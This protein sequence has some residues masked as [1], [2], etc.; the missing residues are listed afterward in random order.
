ML[1]FNLYSNL[2]LIKLR[3]TSYATRC[4]WFSGPTLLAEGLLISRWLVSTLPTIVEMT[5]CVLITSNDNT[6]IRGLAGAHN[7]ISVKLIGII[8]RSVDGRVVTIV[9]HWITA[10]D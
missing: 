1:I 9:V 5:E 6:M 10:S 2:K 3:M 4:S 8:W 7:L